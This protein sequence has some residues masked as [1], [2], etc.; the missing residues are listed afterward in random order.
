MRKVKVYKPAGGD[1][2]LTYVQDAVFHEFMRDRVGHPSAVIE[3]RDGSV[4]CVGIRL[5]QFV[6]PIPCLSCWSEDCSDCNNYEPIQGSV[7]NDN[8]RKTQGTNNRR[9]SRGGNKGNK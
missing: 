6:V 8:R 4:V 3:L 9:P 2:E 1:G 5:I 7:K